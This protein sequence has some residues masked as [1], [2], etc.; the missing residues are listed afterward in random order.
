M[1]ICSSNEKTN[2]NNLN[3]TSGNETNFKTN[4]SK[5]SELIPQTNNSRYFFKL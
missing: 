2:F 4:P 3:S 1:G 5:I